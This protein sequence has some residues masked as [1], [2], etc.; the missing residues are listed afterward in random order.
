MLVLV[1]FLN[2]LNLD[3]HYTKSLINTIYRCIFKKEN[4]EV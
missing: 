4:I 2:I 1:T 3:F